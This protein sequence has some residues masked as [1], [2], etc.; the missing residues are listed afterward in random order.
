MKNYIITIFA[1]SILSI[2]IL[3]C[4]NS[5]LETNYGTITIVNNSSRSI[6]YKG[7]YVDDYYGEWEVDEVVVP[8]SLWKYR[9]EKAILNNPNFDLTTDKSFIVSKYKF[10]GHKYVLDSSATG[11]DRDQIENILDKI[12]YKVLKWVINVILPTDSVYLDPGKSTKFEVIWNNI[13]TPLGDADETRDVKLKSGGRKILTINNH[14]LKGY[15][16]WGSYNDNSTDT[17]YKNYSDLFYLSNRENIKIIIDD[18]SDS[19]SDIIY[20]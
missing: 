14:H 11:S 15:I 6:L 10:Q 16:Y 7:E 19:S 12:G 4:A 1:I 5:E 20:Y 9:F 17:V 3:N 18:L 2:I 8:D 13:G